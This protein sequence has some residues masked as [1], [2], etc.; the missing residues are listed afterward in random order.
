[1]KNTEY[2]SILEIA[3]LSL[4]AER[5]HTANIKIVAHNDPPL[6][7]AAFYTHKLIELI[8]HQRDIKEDQTNQADVIKE[9]WGEGYQAALDGKKLEDNPYAYHD[10]ERYQS[11]Q[12]IAWE[13]G[14]DDGEST[15]YLKSLAI[16]PKE[17]TQHPL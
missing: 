12:S 5:G 2:I 15:L 1:M 4:L 17:N 10:H 7:D 13:R 3:V 11:E 9:C 6:K 16:I 8:Q 14:L